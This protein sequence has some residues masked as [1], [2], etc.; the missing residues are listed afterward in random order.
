MARC[1]RQRRCEVHRLRPWQLA[2]AGWVYAMPTGDAKPALKAAST[3]VRVEPRNGHIPVK[4]ACQVRIN[5]RLHGCHRK[6]TLV[7]ARGRLADIQ[8]QGKRLDRERKAAL[9]RCPWGRGGP[10]PREVS[11]CVAEGVRHP[12]VCQG[13]EPWQATVGGPEQAEGAHQRS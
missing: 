7:P 11:G 5:V 2:A 9:R 8:A 13:T 4:T 12:E 6:P 1:H 10:P 3:V